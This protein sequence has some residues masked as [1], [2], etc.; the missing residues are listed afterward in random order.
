MAN[1]NPTYCIVEGAHRGAYGEKN[2]KL[3]ILDIPLET[4]EIRDGMKNYL[5][6]D[7][8]AKVSGARLEKITQVGNIA[9]MPGAI[10]S[11]EGDGLPVLENPR[12]ILTDDKRIFLER[13]AAHNP[14]YTENLEKV[15]K[16]ATLYLNDESSRARYEELLKKPGRY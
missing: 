11:E 2:F 14:E 8:S 12:L 4:T 7:R 13:D 1:E 5:K 6:W 10:V 9:F 15:I 3:V 16:S